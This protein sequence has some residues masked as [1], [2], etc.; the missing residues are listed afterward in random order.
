MT[1]RKIKLGLA[2]LSHRLHLGFKKESTKMKRKRIR[3][4]YAHLSIMKTILNQILQSSVG[5]V[6][7][8]I[9]RDY[10]KQHKKLSVILAYLNLVHHVSAK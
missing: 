9:I 4:R 6:N 8:G 5:C 1:F 2:I 7:A 10:W 3:K